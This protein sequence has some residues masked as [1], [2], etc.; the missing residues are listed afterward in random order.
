MRKVGVLKSMTSSND[1]WINVACSQSDVHEND[2]VCCIN[3]TWIDLGE[4]ASECC[5]LDKHTMD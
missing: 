4:V 2:V 1:A 3:R 5:V